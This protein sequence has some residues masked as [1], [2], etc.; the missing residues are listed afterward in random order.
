MDAG[1][2]T[3]ATLK[4]SLVALLAAEPIVA[5]G[6]PASCPV[7]AETV[8]GGRRRLSV[9]LTVC[10]EV[11]GPIVCANRSDNDRADDSARR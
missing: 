10:M 4:S 3:V 9:S 7:H 6:H 5:D 8:G 1:V 2:Q 11:V